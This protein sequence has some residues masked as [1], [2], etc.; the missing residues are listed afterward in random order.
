M[1]DFHQ[2]VLWSGE[3]LLGHQRVRLAAR[4][5]LDASER[6]FLVLLEPGLRFR[7]RVRT[8]M[9]PDRVRPGDPGGSLRPAGLGLR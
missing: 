6:P 7:R 3:V 1:N 9:P 5:L 2:V 4:V 8:R